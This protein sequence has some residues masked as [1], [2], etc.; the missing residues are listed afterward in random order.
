MKKIILLSASILFGLLSYSQTQPLSDVVNITLPTNAEKLVSNKVRAFSN[1]FKRNQIDASGKNVY[2]INRELLSFQDVSASETSKKSLQASREEL[3]ELLKRNKAIIIDK[4][5]IVKVNKI[6]F[7]LIKYHEI[8][9]V[10]LRFYSDYNQNI[11][12][13]GLLQYKINDETDAAKVFDGIIK[14]ITF[15]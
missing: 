5:D 1:D 6:D 2:K 14:S 8:D 13:S 3:V 10:Y 12:L 7:L 9:E 15:K 4:A 11:I